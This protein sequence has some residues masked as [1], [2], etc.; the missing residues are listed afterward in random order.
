MKLAKLLTLCWIC[1]RIGAQTLAAEKA[2]E[3]YERGA[4]PAVK[5][6]AAETAAPANSDVFRDLV[7]PVGK[8]IFVDSTLDYSPAATVA[9]TVQCIVCNT[10]ATA[11][12]ASGLMLQARWVVPDATTYVTT[13]N[14][15]T[16]NFPYWDAGGVTFTVYGT[17]LRLSLQNRGSQTIAIEQLT[18]FRRSQ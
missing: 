11:L 9:V 16:A 18:V 8:S 13:E 14:K 5:A 15:T 3:A 12:G 1:G 7:I 17:Q 4:R 2:P 6:A 10:A